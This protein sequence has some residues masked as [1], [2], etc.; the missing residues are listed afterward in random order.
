MDSRQR[1]RADSLTKDHSCCLG[2]SNGFAIIDHRRYFA[3]RAKYTPMLLLRF[4]NTRERRSQLIAVTIE[5]RCG[6]GVDL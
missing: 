2:A 6:E 4:V 1:L 5:D 3:T